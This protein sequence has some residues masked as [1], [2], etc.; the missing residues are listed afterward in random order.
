MSELDKIL[1]D[2]K[3]AIEENIL[4][5]KAEDDAKLKKIKAHYN[6]QVAQANLTDFTRNIMIK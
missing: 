3:K 5:A 1:L 6:L 2:L 4:A